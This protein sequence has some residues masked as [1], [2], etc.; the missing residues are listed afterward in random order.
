MRVVPFDGGDD[1]A[2]IAT[3][4][5]IDFSVVALTPLYVVPS[6]KTFIGTGFVVRFRS[7]SPNATST[8]AV[9]RNSDGNPIF[10]PT[11]SGPS[12]PPDATT[13]S[14][15]IYTNGIFPLPCPVEAGDT[16]QLDIS[17]ADTGTAPICDVDLL[18][19]LV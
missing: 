16:V 2:P 10:I 4:T 18:G 5:G 9:E 1:M 3:V 7:G 14:Y 15:G 12:N 6:G 13:F 8:W 17:I 11:A 19:Y